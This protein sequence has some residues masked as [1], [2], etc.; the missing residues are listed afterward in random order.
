MTWIDISKEYLIGGN[1]YM[2]E[3]AHGN[4]EIIKN[5]KESEDFWDNYES[6][7]ETG[8]HL[9]Y[10]RFLKMNQQKDGID[11]YSRFVDLLVNYYKDKN[12]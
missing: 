4:F 8:F 7:V 3:T 5:Y 12:L 1:I 10:D 6:F 11:S 9:F 2:L